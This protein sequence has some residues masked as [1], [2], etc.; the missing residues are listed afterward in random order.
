MTIARRIGDALRGAPTI[1]CQG[2]CGACRR[3]LSCRALER[4][5]FLLCFGTRGDE[6]ALDIGE[7]VF[8]REP[9]SAGSRRIRRGRE[10]VPPPEVALARDQPLADFQPRGKVGSF[11]ATDNN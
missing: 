5:A 7:P 10:P 1:T 2:L 4:A 6:L 9:P 8:L 11:A 3:D